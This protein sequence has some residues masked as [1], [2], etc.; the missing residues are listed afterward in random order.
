VTALSAADDPDPSPHPIELVFQNT[1]G[2]SDLA[3]RELRP[4]L[5]D[6]L[7]E[8]APW[9]GSLGVLFGGDRRLADLN[10]RFRG[11]TGPTDVLSFP[12]EEDGTPG[13]HLGDIAISVPTARRQA[14]SAG[15]DL[16]HEI[17]VLLLHGVLHCLGHDH[18][19]DSGEM[20]SLER[21]LRRQWIA[22][23]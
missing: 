1:S 15:H 10:Q 21:K 5:R 17:R 6:L 20:E 14:E 8:L 4:W 11:K 22:Q 9:A 7:G 2:A 23:R 3:L 19:A 18:E 16:Q 13:G 12:G